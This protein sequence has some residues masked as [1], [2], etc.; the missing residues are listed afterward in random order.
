MYINSRLE[1]KG[2][3]VS[4]YVYPHGVTVVLSGLYIRLGGEYNRQFSQNK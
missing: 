3:G 1:G 4:E 2:E